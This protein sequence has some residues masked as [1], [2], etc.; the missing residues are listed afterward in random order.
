MKT[1][2]Q[3]LDKDFTIAQVDNRLFGTFIEPIRN[4]IYGNLYNPN[5]PAADENGFRKDIIELMKE[6]RTTL[7]RYP[8]GNFLSGY[9]WVDGIGPKADRPVRY[10]KAWLKT[11]SNQIGIDEYYDYC[12]LLGVEPNLAVNLGTGSVESAADEV[13]RKSVV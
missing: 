13:D 2:R 8:G 11:E 5:H 4:I 1:A 12:R 9:N 3:I 6:L 10:D 7:I